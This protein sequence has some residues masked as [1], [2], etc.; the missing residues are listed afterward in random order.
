MLL[1]RKSPG[2]CFNIQYGLCLL[3]QNYGG[4][5]D[6]FYLSRGLK[7][8]KKKKKRKQVKRQV[9]STDNLDMKRFKMHVKKPPDHIRSLPRLH[10]PCPKSM[11]ETSN[12]HKYPVITSSCC[13]LRSRCILG[14]TLVPFFFF[15]LLSL[16]CLQAKLG[17]LWLSPPSPHTTRPPIPAT[18]AA[19]MCWLSRGIRSENCFFF[20]YE[21]W[22]PSLLEGKSPTV[23]MTGLCWEEWGWDA[24]EIQPQWCCLSRDIKISLGNYLLKTKTHLCSCSLLLS[25]SKP[26]TGGVKN[27]HVNSLGGYK[28][29]PCFICATHCCTNILHSL[30]GRWCK[31][32]WDD[33]S[34]LRIKYQYESPHRPP[35]SPPD[36]DAS[37]KNGVWLQFWDPSTTEAK[38]FN[39]GL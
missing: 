32:V 6:V 37:N 35:W 34:L 27:S 4:T 29:S 10:L 13:P 26:P 15:S 24:E 17:R 12:C 28:L 33:S 23:L 7:E 5:M 31:S 9:R 30:N 1:K 22:T 16:T 21:S 36:V 8:K 38:K 20:S 2:V 19:L 18:A 14:Q 3:A 39:L 11:D 25:Q